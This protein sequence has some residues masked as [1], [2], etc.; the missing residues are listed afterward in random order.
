[1]KRAIPRENTENRTAENPVGRT[2][3]DFS[4]EE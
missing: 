4:E 2:N 1:M 3:L